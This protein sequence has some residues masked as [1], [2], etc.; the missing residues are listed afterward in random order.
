MSASVRGFLLIAG[1]SFAEAHSA[2]PGESCLTNSALNLESVPQTQ[3]V[4]MELLD[5]VA[6]RTGQHG[7]EMPPICY[8]T[9]PQLARLRDE[10]GDGAGPFETIALYQRDPPWIYVSYVFHPDNPVSQSVIVHEL[11][12]HAQAEAGKRFACPQMAE[13]EAYELQNEWLN[14]FGLDVQSALRIND[15]GYF[16]LTNCGI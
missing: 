14:Q 1:L 3:P 5:W 7:L 9:H 12:H 4:M 10:G 16:L 6:A 2:S 8:V 11:V 15:L 13:R